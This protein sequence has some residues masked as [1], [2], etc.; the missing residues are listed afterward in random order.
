MDGTGSLEAVIELRRGATF[1]LDVELRARAGETV[2]VLG[3]NGAGKSTCMSVIAGTTR[4]DSGRVT[5]G[6]RVLDDG[7]A[8][9]FVPPEDR[10]LGVVFQGQVLF[11]HLT[12]EQNVA[13]GLRA[14][15]RGL[16]REAAR[17]RARDWLER[18]GLPRDRFQARPATLSGG[19]AQRVALA[20]ALAIEPD[21]VLLDEPF[22]AVDASGR[23]TLQRALRAHLADFAGPR[24]VVVHEIGDAL[25][26]GVD[27]F[28]VLEGGRVAQVGAFDDLVRRPGSRY[29]ADLLGVNGFLGE[30]QDGVFQ[31]GDARLTVASA[32]EGAVLVT[33]HPTAVS[34]FRE[35]PSGSPRNVL[36][37]RV[38]AVE[39]LVD[40]V[41]VQVD[42]ELSMVAEITPAAVVELDLVEGSEVWVA[43]KATE[44]V[45]SGV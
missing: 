13:F 17:R 14:G 26:L 42:G 3:P 35:R 10:R 34:L 41:R 33:I 9:R 24:V 32:L 38:G 15:G 27:R 37:G 25:A 5:L 1:A 16:T 22:A 44:I 11:P 20:R 6:E 2:A 36:N 19:Q 40:R 4:I 8:G 21:A 30:C 7:S 23:R 43:V 12:A 28:V 29:V 31:C 39:R 45:V 18:V